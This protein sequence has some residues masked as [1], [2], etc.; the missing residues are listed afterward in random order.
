MPKLLTSAPRYRR[1]KATGQAVVR[2]DGRDIYLGKHGTAASREAYKRFLAQWSQHGGQLPAPKH[3][4]TVAELVV[5]YVEFANRYYRKDGK[6]TDEVRM[7]KT[8]LKIV[9]KLYGRTPAA[10]FGPLA[11]KA[12]RE[13]MI[14]QDWCRTHINKQVDRVKRAF[15]WAT[16]NEMVPGTVYEALRCVAGL[17]RGRTEAREGLKVKP[18]SDTDVLATMEHLPAVVADMVQLQR[19]TG[20][21]PGEICDIRPGD[22]NRKADPWEYVPQSHKTEHHDRPRVIFLGPKAQKLLLPYLLR[23]ADSYCFS[24][25]EAESKRRAAQ[26]EARQTPIN[27]GNRPGTNRKAKPRRIAGEKYDRNSYARAVRRAAVAAV[28]GTWSPH[29]LRHTFATEVRKSYGLEAVQVCLGHSKADT[30]QIYAE[31]VDGGSKQ[32]RGAAEKSSAGL[33]KFS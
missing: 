1:H 3:T 19:L 21:R 4:A 13:Q 30:T 12:C 8:T 32:R 17:K 18:I 6:V 25:R 33:V 16:E 9:R 27:C 10:E 11:L 22:I 2:L 29:R 23:P 15:K 31:R 28:V 26:H 14:T 7:L 20:A 5:A 24:P